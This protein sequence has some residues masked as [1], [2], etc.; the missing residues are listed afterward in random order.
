M[1]GVGGSDAPAPA[2]IQGGRTGFSPSSRRRR[3]LLPSVAVVVVALAVVAA[4]FATGAIHPNPASA[5]NPSFETFSQAES[6]AGAGAGTVAGGP[7]YPVFGAAA[8][9]RTATLEPTTNLSSLLAMTNCT[10][11]WAGGEPANLGIPATPSSAG[12]GTSAYWTFGLKNASNGLLV[13]TVS[14]GLASALLTVG[15]TACTDLLGYLATFPS[16]TLDSPAIIASANQ[17]GGSTFLGAHA[18]STEVW[19]AYGGATDFGV[20]TSP[21]WFVEYTSC[22]V[23][24][25]PG[26]TGAVFNATVGG[27]S[28]KVISSANGTADCVLTAPTGLAL[29]VSMGLPPTAARKAI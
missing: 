11:G 10:F 9:I 21:E 2:S 23:P 4:L 27:T 14:D 17:V 26:E 24:T 5:T 15:G 8:L 22:S 3:W 13:E 6:V 12:I 1:S 20:F 18:N 16:G 25:T 28:G 19:G 7:W 29:T